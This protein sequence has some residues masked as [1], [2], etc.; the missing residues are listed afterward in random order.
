M[1]PSHGLAEA[2]LEVVDR[3]REQKP[4]RDGLDRWECIVRIIAAQDSLPSSEVQ[5]IEEA[6]A[7]A[8]AG[9]SHEQRLSIWYETESG[10]ADEPDDDSPYEIVLDGSG[11]VLRE[12]MLDEVTKEARQQARELRRAAPKR[13][14]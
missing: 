7:E 10:M 13:R 5:V 9:W 4:G 3:L 6:I 12:E 1:G 8:C 11:Y 14:R 2:V